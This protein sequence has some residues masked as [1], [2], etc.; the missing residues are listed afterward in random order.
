MTYV[1]S[2]RVTSLNM[3]MDWQT[4]K[5]LFGWIDQNKGRWVRQ[6]VLEMMAKI[7]GKWLQI[8]PVFHT[9]WK[10]IFYQSVFSCMLIQGRFSAVDTAVHETWWVL[11][12]GSIMTSFGWMA[13]TGGH[14]I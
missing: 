10:D 9:S 7:C 8:S 3:D 2:Y 1:V 12:S 6:I 4:V 14:W 5:W 13:E 11:V